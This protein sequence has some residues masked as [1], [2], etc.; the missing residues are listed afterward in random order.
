MRIPTSPHDRQRA[1]HR[2]VA[3]VGPAEDTCND[4]TRC[5]NRQ[6]VSSQEFVADQTN[7]CCIVPD[8]G[9]SC[10][11]TPA[12][13]GLT[14]M[15][16]YAAASAVGSAQSSL[17]LRPLPPQS[18]S[19]TSGQVPANAAWVAWA[20]I[21]HT[22]AR[23]WC[24]GQPGFGRPE[25]SSH[26]ATS[27]TSPPGSPGA[28]AGTSPWTCPKAGTQTRTDNPVP[29]RL[30]AVRLTSPDPVTAPYRLTACRR[31]HPT[32]TT[33]KPQERRAPTSS[34]CGSAL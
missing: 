11:R 23:L 28:A 30:R 10:L 31:S 12:D 3:R 26:V 20:A 24:S 5:L 4:F 22:T 8:V 17:S 1:C 19:P 14:V 7:E 9:F 25:A 2:G 18:C 34:C 29:H 32:R 13:R 21:S 33:D 27:S 6:G 15:V 16:Y